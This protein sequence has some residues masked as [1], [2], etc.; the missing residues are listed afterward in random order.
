MSNMNTV[1]NSKPQQEEL[2]CDYEAGGPTQLL[3]NRYPSKA[4]GEIY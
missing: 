1:G 2:I 4:V 3:L